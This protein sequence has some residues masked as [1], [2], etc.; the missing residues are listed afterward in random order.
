[1]GR[2]R[3]NVALEHASQIRNGGEDPACDDVALDAGKPDLDLIQPGR[4]SGRELQMHIGVL[5]A[6]L[7]C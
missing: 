7:P 1:M 4:V 3:P 6:D 2:V 5:V